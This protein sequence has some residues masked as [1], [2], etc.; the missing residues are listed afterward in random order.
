VFCFAVPS[1][2][3]AAP[4]SAQITDAISSL[5]MYVQHD[6]FLIRCAASANVS[7]NVA[8]EAAIVFYSRDLTTPETASS[9]AHVSGSLLPRNTSE[10]QFT[11]LRSVSHV[12]ATETYN[13]AYYLRQQQRESGS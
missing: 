8:R 12:A 10:S 1:P 11:V 3:V 5:G 4:S 7:S 13:A 9:A 2:F 6:S